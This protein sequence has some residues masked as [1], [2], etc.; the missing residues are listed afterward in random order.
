MSNYTERPTIDYDFRKKSGLNPKMPVWQ[1][2]LFAILCLASLAII[3]SQNKKINDQNILIATLQAENDI[4]PEKIK[5]LE[6]QI[7]NDQKTINQ[8]KAQVAT[9]EATIEK[10]TTPTPSP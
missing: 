10:L 2:W 9:L 6:T 3:V 1:I 7:A 8:L 4:R 5:N